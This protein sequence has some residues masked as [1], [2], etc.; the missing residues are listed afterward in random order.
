MYISIGLKK[1]LDTEEEKRMPWLDLAVKYLP[2]KLTVSCWLELD[3]SVS[4]E[5]DV[6]MRFGLKE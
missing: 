1:K 5:V 2:G 4:F 6:A 3:L